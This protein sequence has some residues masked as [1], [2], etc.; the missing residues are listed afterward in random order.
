MT[1][2]PIQRPK[3][4][5]NISKRYHKCTLRNGDEV[6]L[7]NTVLRFDEAEMNHE[8]AASPWKQLV[9]LDGHGHNGMVCSARYFPAI[10]GFL[11]ELL[12]NM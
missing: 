7:G 6:R 9:I 11:D 10:S 3:N 5:F 8:A 1:L 2:M 12:R 4:I